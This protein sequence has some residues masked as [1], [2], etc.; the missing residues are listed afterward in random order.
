MSMYQ[1]MRKEQVVEHVAVKFD[2]P[3][4]RPDDRR[5]SWCL[6]FAHYVPGNLASL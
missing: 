1:T 5:G 6:N 2:D 4:T 3:R